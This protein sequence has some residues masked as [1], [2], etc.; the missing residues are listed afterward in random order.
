MKPSLNNDDNHQNAF[1][2]FTCA[3]QFYL[4]TFPST[5][6]AVFLKLNTSNSLVEKSF[7]AKSLSRKTEGFWIINSS[8]IH[9]ARKGYFLLRRWKPSKQ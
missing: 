5:E 7:H 3:E 9:C 1:L 6:N 4:N 2:I 8:V